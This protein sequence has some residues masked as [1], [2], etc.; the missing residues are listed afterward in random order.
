MLKIKSSTFVA[1]CNTAAAEAKCGWMRG[2]VS[3]WPAC[4][5]HAAAI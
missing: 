2:L 4:L 1:K 3:T 5:P